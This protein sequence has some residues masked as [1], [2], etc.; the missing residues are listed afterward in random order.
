MERELVRSE[1]STLLIGWLVCN[2][3]HQGEK[4]TSNGSKGFRLKGRKPRPPS[5]EKVQLPLKLPEKGIL[6][7]NSGSESSYYS[8]GFFLSFPQEQERR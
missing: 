8:T 5:K 6:S 3:I 7:E 4:A 1:G 2:P